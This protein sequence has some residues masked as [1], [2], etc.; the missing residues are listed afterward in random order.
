[1]IAWEGYTRRKM[2]EAV[3]EATG[4]KV[5]AKYGWLVRRDGDADAH[6]RRRPVRHGLGIRRREPTPDLRQGR[7]PGE[8]K[9]RPGLEEVLH[10]LSESPPNNTVGGQHYGI[11]LQ[12]GPNTLLY[13]TK[14]VKPK[15]ERAGAAIYSS[16]YKGE[17]TVPN[18][19]IQIADAALYLS[20]TQPSLGI[21]DPYELNEAQFDA[22]IDLMKKQK[23][24]IKKY[25]ASSGDE[26]DLF[27][28]GGAVDR[29]VVAR[30]Q[31]RARG[32]KGAREGDDPEGRSDGL[33]RHVDALV[34]GEASELCRVKWYQVRL[35][36]RR[37]RLSRRRLRRD[38]G[39]TRRRARMMDKLV[40]GL[41][42]HVPRQTRR[43]RTPLDQVLE[44]AGRRLW[45]RP[46][47][48]HGLHEVALSLDDIRRS[49]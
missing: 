23:P 19:P 16:K 17:I 32:R 30:Y 26:I 12:W 41:V 5:Q 1:M 42:P 37:C 34:E 6:R 2:G 47:E 38:A 29:G 28:N 15:P 27:K 24:L 18:N 31:T 45:Q 35:D 9:S 11:S 36:A 14:K 21:K 3:R 40:Q 44:D 22:A 33:A 39:R 8:L 20:K 25:W 43:R 48:L 49:S 7:P 13:N 4:C 46:E 10:G